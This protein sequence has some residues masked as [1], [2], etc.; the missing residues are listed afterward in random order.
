[1]EQKIPYLNCFWN[2]V[3]HFTTVHPR[4]IK[5][6]LGSS[7]TFKAFS[8]DPHVLEPANTIV[9]LHQQNDIREKTRAD[10]VEYNP[11]E[12]AQYKE[13]PEATKDYYKRMRN[14]GKRPLMF[15]RVPHILHKG[16]IDTSAPSVEIIEV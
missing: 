4:K 12:V 11:N 14:Q 8:I 15:V 1:M 7:R 13:I 5:A 9:Y 10:F 16:S 3:L 6:A 2:D